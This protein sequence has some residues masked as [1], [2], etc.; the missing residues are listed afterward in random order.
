MTNIPNFELETHFRICDNINGTH[1][2]VKPDADGLDL[3]EI[4]D[5]NQPALRLVMT[6]D[7]ANLLIEALESLIDKLP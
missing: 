4:N 6:K 7:Q 1:I 5:S 2:V 3:I